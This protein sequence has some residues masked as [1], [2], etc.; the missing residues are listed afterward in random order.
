MIEQEINH[1]VNQ[2]VNDGKLRATADAT[3]GVLNS[4]LSMICVG[5]PGKRNGGLNPTYVKSV[6]QDI[7]KAIAMKNS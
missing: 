5:T 4:D 6:C 7:G 1:I 2:V 3:D